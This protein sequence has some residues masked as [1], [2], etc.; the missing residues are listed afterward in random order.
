MKAS[1]LKS[2]ALVITLVL[3]QCT[4][5]RAQ[6][7]AITWSKIA[8]GAGTCTNGSYSLSGTI[9]Q[10]DAGGPLTNSHY[11]VAGGFWVP[12]IA[13]Q[14]TG[15]PRLT[16]VSSSPGQAT[17]AWSPNTPG[18]VLQESL[19]LSPANWINSPSGATNPVI[20]PA[21]LPAKFYRLFSP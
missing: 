1:I 12:P 21:T 4:V 9:G 8:S 17:V 11:S 18:F 3:G 5:L 6:T 2:L 16:I 7:Y 10:L 19:S 20:L 13:V 15:A 14:V